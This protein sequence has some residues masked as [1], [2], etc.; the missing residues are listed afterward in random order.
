MVREITDIG[1]LVEFLQSGGK[2]HRFDFELEYPENDGLRKGLEKMD[3][4]SGIERI[5]PDNF[6]YFTSSKTTD[7]FLNE[8]SSNGLTLPEKSIPEYITAKTN[9]DVK[10]ML[11]FV[12]IINGEESKIFWNTRSAGYDSLEHLLGEKNV[13][14]ASL[15]KYCIKGVAETALGLAHN[16]IKNDNAHV[17]GLNRGKKDSPEFKSISR[18]TLAV[19]GCGNIGSEVVKLAKMAGYKK[20]VAIDARE[21][22]LSKKKKYEG[23]EFVTPL[24]GM[25]YDVIINVMNLTNA[26]NLFNNA[27]Y[28]NNLLPKAK[29]GAIFVN[30]ARGEVVSYELARDLLKSKRLYGFASDTHPQ[31]SKFRAGLEQLYELRNNKLLPISDPKLINEIFNGNKEH[32]VGYDLA[33]AGETR[34]MNVYLH[35]HGGFKEVDGSRLKVKEG[36]NIYTQY[37][38]HGHFTKPVTPYTNKDVN[39]LPQHADNYFAYRDIANSKRR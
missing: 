5:L 24:E 19:Y 2:V 12:R 30:A 27:G 11:D 15:P 1:E 18:L 22:T 4:K 32:I 26:D 37:L 36:L 16:C 13:E 7:A 14:F 33:V 25:K 17:S 28:F 6:T 8:L 31:E 29:K 34:Q 3:N 10:K 21:A 23:I 35:P 20:V 39:I 9:S 38:K